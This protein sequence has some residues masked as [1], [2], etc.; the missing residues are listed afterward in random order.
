M[1][2]LQIQF[3][4]AGVGDCILI[5]DLVH[6]KKIL[7]DS[8]PSKGEG[9]LSVSQNLSQLLCHDKKIDIAIITHNDDDHIGGFKSLIEEEIINV[10]K[11]IFNNIKQVESNIVESKKASY[12][13]DIELHTLANKMGINIDVMIVEDD[14]PNII[15]IG[16]MTLKFMSPNKNK[17]EQLI[18]W[19]QSESTKINDRQK[20][21]PT[22]TSESLE[23]VIKKIKDND[24]FTPDKSPTNGSSIAFILE[25][26]EYKFLFLGDAHMDIV[27][28]FFSREAEKINFELIKLS[29]HSSEKNNS[30]A[31]FD[32]IFCDKF[33]FCCN[34]LNN[35][36]HPSLVTI[37]RLSINFPNSKLF[38]TS[39]NEDIKR[40]TK[41]FSSRCTYSAD[42]ILEFNYEL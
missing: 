35:H 23:D 18:R 31:F 33:I 37:A 40:I 36:G 13:Q 28:D 5:T 16:A 20:L 34:G 6:K 27:E 19:S 42:G 4:D 8:G 41:S 1:N 14:I 29:H 30:K 38:F 9:R 12:R 21:S 3:I 26:G 15:N 32:Q 7:I 24:C 17:I 39:D 10:D 25:Y 22:C 2:G 11:F